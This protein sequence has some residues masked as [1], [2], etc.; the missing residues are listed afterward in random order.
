MLKNVKETLVQFILKYVNIL[1][2]I[3]ITYFMI[4]NIELKK[5]LIFI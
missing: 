3:I 4:Y 5:V 2:H 1:Y